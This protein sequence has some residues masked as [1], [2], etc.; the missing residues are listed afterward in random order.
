MAMM[1]FAI[2][3]LRLDSITQ[4]PRYEDP[5]PYTITQ[6]YDLTYSKIFDLN[7]LSLRAK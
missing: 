2:R 4:V 6:V 1:E 5:D 7:P 3:F